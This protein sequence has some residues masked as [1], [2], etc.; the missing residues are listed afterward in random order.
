M[1][2]QRR[3]LNICT[4]LCDSWAPLGGQTTEANED[5]KLSPG[6]KSSGPN[7]LKQIIQSNARSIGVQLKRVENVSIVIGLITKHADYILYRMAFML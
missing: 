5:H 2:K 6:G 3:R 4:V 1:K 7:Q